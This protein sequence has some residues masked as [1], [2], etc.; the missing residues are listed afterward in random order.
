MSIFKSKKIKETQK[1]YSSLRKIMAQLEAFM[2]GNNSNR[3]Q[4]E[5]IHEKVRNL[6]EQFVNNENVI[7][8]IGDIYLA[9]GIIFL[10][11]QNWDASINA[12]DK[13]IKLNDGY[14]T[15]NAHKYKGLILLNE[16]NDPR[17]ALKEF[18]ACKKNLENY[19]NTLD[20][21]EKAE[22]IIQGD[23]DIGMSEVENLIIECSQRL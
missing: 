13:C 15:V 14:D 8:P 22:I 20:I 21:L 2:I 16:K 19:T 6:E 10:L 18:K 3:R 7:I 23:G 5:R 12:L 9:Y 1:Y 4:L 17:G 11:Y